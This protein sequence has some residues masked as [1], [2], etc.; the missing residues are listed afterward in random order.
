ML[1][2]ASK[3]FREYL[4]FKQ[5]YSSELMRGVL[6]ATSV[7]NSR[8]LPGT[9]HL[10]RA[11]TPASNNQTGSTSSTPLYRPSPLRDVTPSLDSSHSS[12]SQPPNS[13]SG[14][15][16]RA[17]SFTVP[18][19]DSAG[20]VGGATDLLGAVGR[21]QG[22]KQCGDGVRGEEDDEEDD[23]DE[24]C[25]PELQKIRMDG[26]SSYEAEKAANIA[27]NQE[28]LQ[29][30]GLITGFKELHES[31]VQNKR[32]PSRRPDSSPDAPVPRTTRSSNA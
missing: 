18:D 6:T 5:V 16:S 29:Q 28:V 31:L 30:L 22:E 24:G 2:F 19:R 10:R 20:S 14:D 15:W 3:V 26:F 7:C 21:V 17:A 12:Q 32:A 25:V 1:D 27:R 9:E 8:A 11:Y 23:N 13:S 4:C